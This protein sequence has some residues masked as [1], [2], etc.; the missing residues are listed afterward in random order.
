MR[1]HLGV[2]CG[3]SVCQLQ[4]MEPQTEGTDIRIDIKQFCLRM[5]LAARSYY[6][7]AHTLH[8]FSLYNTPVLD[9]VQAVREAVPPR[10]ITVLCANEVYGTGLVQALEPLSHTVRS[11]QSPAAARKHAAKTK[12]ALWVITHEMLTQPDQPWRAE[13]NTPVLV[14]TKKGMPAP[15]IPNHNGK[16]LQL[17]MPVSP[18][19]LRD[20]VSSLLTQEV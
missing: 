16:L 7:A 13:R 8:D 5:C 4:A 11:F 2:N 12:C 3:T 6:D 14:L 9:F 17:P 1:F 10:E 18:Q 20:C 15:V 19:G